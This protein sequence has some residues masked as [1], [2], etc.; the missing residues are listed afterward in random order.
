MHLRRL[1]DAREAAHT[2]AKLQAPQGVEGCIG[3]A[4]ALRRRLRWHRRWP[5]KGEGGGG[6]W[7]V[8]RP[9]Q[10]GEVGPQPAAC[11]Q[12]GG[13]SGPR[14]LV[15]QREA[16]R[17]AR[18]LGPRLARARLA[19]GQR[20]RLP[21]G[22]PG[23]PAGRRPRRGALP[24]ARPLPGAHER[25]EERRQPRQGRR[26]LEGGRLQGLRHAGARRALRGAH[27][28]TARAP[29]L[30]AGRG[31]AALRPGARAGGLPLPRPPGG[32][33]RGGA[34]RW[35]RGPDAAPPGEPLREGPLEH[36][37]EGQDLPGRGGRGHRSRGGQ[38]AERLGARRP[39]V[40]QPGRSHL[41]RRHR[42]QRRAA[43]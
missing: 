24:G 6:C 32:E 5:G 28:G 42:P 4:A 35:R 13:E 9:A 41:L 39:E 19:A 25:G 1:E 8:R 27:G 20:D 21:G 15:D 34:G 2:S 38:G 37:A 10:R 26:P 22:P 17:D 12:V 23:G 3:R 11:E 36:P 18:L 29:G 7:R 14:G 31:G 43:R 40:P 33:A 30:R 16:G